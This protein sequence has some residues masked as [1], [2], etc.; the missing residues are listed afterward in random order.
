MPLPCLPVAVLGS[1]LPKHAV[2]YWYWSYSRF[3]SRSVGK[4]AHVVQ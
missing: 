1:V 3:M 4:A 2:E